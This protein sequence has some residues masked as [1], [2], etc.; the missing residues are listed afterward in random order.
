V[1]ANIVSTANRNDS[2][3]RST[4]PPASQPPIVKMA[5]PVK[6]GNATHKCHRLGARARFVNVWSN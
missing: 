1:K 4:Q 5:A 3:D 2:A 6:P